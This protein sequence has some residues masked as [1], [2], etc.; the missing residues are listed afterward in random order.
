MTYEDFREKTVF[1]KLSQ[2]FDRKEKTNEIGMSREWNKRHRN[3]ASKTLVNS[4]T[5]FG[6]ISPLWQHIKVFEQIL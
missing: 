1:K 4:V 3:G 2:Y 5:K 6:E